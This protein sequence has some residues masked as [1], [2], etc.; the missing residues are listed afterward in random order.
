MKF[1]LVQFRQIQVCFPIT[2]ISGQKKTDISS[3]NS[4]KRT[5]QFCS[6]RLVIFCIYF[7]AQW[8]EVS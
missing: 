2:V 7:F 4:W 6:I 5:K 1:G 3:C 8:I